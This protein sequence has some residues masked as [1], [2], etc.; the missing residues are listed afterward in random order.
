MEVS[1]PRFQSLAGR[2]VL[3]DDV[4]AHKNFANYHRLRADPPYRLREEDLR[5]RNGYAI[6]E[7]IA[8][9]SAAAATW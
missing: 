6:F 1:A 5:L 9:P 8:R 2:Y 7:G 3:L 4:V